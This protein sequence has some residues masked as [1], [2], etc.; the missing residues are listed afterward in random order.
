V[1]LD[2]STILLI[3]AF[4]AFAL[5]AIGRGYKKTNLPATAPRLGVLSNTSDPRTYS[6]SRFTEGSPT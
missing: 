3:L 5:S 2:S 1:T 4:I 6:P